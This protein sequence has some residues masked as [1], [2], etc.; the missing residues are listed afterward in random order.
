MFQFQKY[1]LCFLVFF[2]TKNCM[3]QDLDETNLS[4][5]ILSYH[6][7]VNTHFGAI[8][9]HIPQVSYA[10]GTS[11]YG[12]ELEL[13]KNREDLDVLNTTKQKF[14][15]GY[16]L[17]Y[18]RFDNK[19]FGNTS[20]NAAYFIEPYFIN[21]KKIKLGIRG[22][23][24]LNY[25]DNPYH[26]I[27][28]PQNKSYS[29]YINSYLLFAFCSYVQLNKNDEL[30]VR[31]NYAHISNG[32]VHD[33]NHGINFP[34]VSVGLKHKLKKQKEILLKH[35]PDENALW[36][37]DATAFATVRTVSTLNQNYVWISGIWFSASRKISKLNAIIFSADWTNDKSTE[38]LLKINNRGHLSHQRIGVGVGNEF[39]F[40]NFTFSQTIGMYAFSQTQY[41]DLI[42]HRWIINYKLNRKISVGIGLLANAN[43]A[44]FTD[45]RLTYNF[46]K[47]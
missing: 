23:I 7:S 4:K 47:K 37:F 20:L 39:I 5:K 8:W 41:I 27:D 38:A 25:S 40:K 1:L 44:N 28:N 36:R 42:Y 14:H 45:I 17:N 13:Q 35:F 21:R 34:T 3:S 19:I 26:A 43:F 29:F 32:A 11:V 2:Q 46:Y 33:P 10:A 24:G 12:I 30:Q 16:V 22:A 6:L 31:L 9:A 15:S 18:F